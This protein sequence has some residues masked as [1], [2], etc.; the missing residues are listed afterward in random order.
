MVLQDWNIY[1]L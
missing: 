1:K